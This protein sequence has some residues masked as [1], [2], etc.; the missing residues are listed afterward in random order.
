MRC[1]LPPPLPGAAGAEHCLRCTPPTPPQVDMNCWLLVYPRRLQDVTKNLVALLRSACGPIGMQVNQPALVELKD[2]RLE[3]YVRTIRSILGN[4]VGVLSWG[5]VLQLCALISGLL[6]CVST[7]DKVQ[8][9]LCI[10]TGTKADVYSAIKKLCCVHSPV[11]SQVWG[12]RWAPPRAGLG[13]GQPPN[14][15]SPPTGHQ[16]ALPPG[17]LGQTEEHCAEGAAADELQ[18]GRRALGG[19]R[20]SGERCTWGG[21]A[22]PLRPRGGH[23]PHTPPRNASLCRSS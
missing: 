21:W 23:S 15:R 8:L 14:L 1:L 5:G 6:C 20:P 2:E 18:A 13:V 7:Q 16:R 9:L 10:T 22:A 17:P 11:P 19:G 3:T 4:E 12:W